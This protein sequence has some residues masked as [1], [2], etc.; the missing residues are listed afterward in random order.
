L[1]LNCL[2]NGL[3]SSEKTLKKVLF[4]GQFWQNHAK[5]MINDR[6]KKLIDRLL[7]GFTGKLTSSKWAKIAH[8]SKDTAIRDINDLIAKGILQ[9]EDSGGRNTSYRIAALLNR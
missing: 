5:T 4:K 1:F 8:C 6:Q 7:D 2:I 9:K 3:N